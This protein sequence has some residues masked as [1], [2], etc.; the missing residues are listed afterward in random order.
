MV[1]ARADRGLTSGDR[2]YDEDHA[3]PEWEAIR[4]PTIS[5][6]RCPSSS[7][8]LRGDAPFGFSIGRD[9]MV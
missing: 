4:C 5:A 2:G 8:R 7:I 9:N 1:R 6:G 3:K